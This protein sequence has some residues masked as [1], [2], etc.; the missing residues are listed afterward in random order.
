MIENTQDDR[1]G[2]SNHNDIMDD[3]GLYDADEPLDGYMT[4]QD[5]DLLADRIP[6]DYYPGLSFSHYKKSHYK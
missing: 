4:V 1:R 2:R 5:A 6:N 3:Y